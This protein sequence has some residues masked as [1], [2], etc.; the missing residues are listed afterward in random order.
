MKKILVFVD[1]FDFGGVTSLIKDIYRNN[2]IQKCR[3][4]FV[5]KNR[6]INEF[7]E[8]IVNNGDT[9]Y[10]YDDVNLG[11][12]PVLNYKIKS[13]IMIKR[14]RKIIG[15]EK[16]DVA[17]IHAN[18]A[19]CVMAAKKLKIPKIIMHSHE[20]VSDFGG[21][22]KISKI[23]AF[24]WNKRVKM[25]NQLVDFKVGDS[26][27]ACIAKFGES[28]LNEDKM[29]VIHPPINLDK[30]NPE[31]YDKEKAVE[32]FNVDTDSF[33]MIHVGRLCEVKNQQFML[34]ILSEIIKTRKCN[35]YIVGEGDYEKEKLILK[36]KELG[37]E[38]FVHFL[39]GNTSP[40]IYTAMDCSL[41]PS[42]SE[43]FGMVAVESQLMGIP[44]FASTNVPD[45]VNVGMC[46]FVDLNK[47]KESWAKHILSYDYSNCSVNEE[48]AGQF[49]INVIIESL[50]K[51]FLD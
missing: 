43:A 48:L 22:E 15:K 51:M 27:K 12:I 21:N 18:A 45:D 31:N 16:Y 23:T 39:P 7:D 41:L 20:A 32:D 6:N 42:F 25:Y 9:V 5:R 34:D 4:F 14:L 38:K 3:M 26:K 17:Y 33:N 8:E 44:C 36:A 37:V 28:V 13:H 10:Y 40:A 24:V 35:L 19:Y 49:D 29:R 11:K 30:F 47:G 1:T 46:S 50:T 2:N